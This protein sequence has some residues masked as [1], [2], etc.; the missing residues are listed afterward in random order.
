MRVLL[1]ANSLMPD[2]GGP[3][4]SVSRLAVALSD[5]GVQVGLWASDQSAVVTPLLRDE[6]RVTR[7]GGSESDAMKSFAPDVLHDNGI[8]MPHHHRYAQLAAAGKI[9]RL[10]STRGMLAPWALGH[11]RWKKRAAWWLYQR[12]DLKRALRHHV[13]ADAEAGHVRALGLGVPVCVI[14]NGIDL[15]EMAQGREL[16][17]KAGMSAGGKRIALFLGRIYPVKGLPMLIEAW[18]RVRPEGWALQLAG[19]DEAG[20]RAQVAAVITRT[21]L[22]DAISFAGPI[23]GPE[24]QAALFSAELFVL[25]THSEN[26]G[27]AVGEALAHGLPVLTTTGA[28]WPMLEPRGC[29]WWVHPTVEGLAA[30]LARATSLDTATLRAMGDRGRDLVAAEFDWGSVARKF[31][32]LYRLVKR[33]S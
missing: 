2:Y 7:L 12:R 21:G 17:R 19:P 30:G 6:T 29:G 27:M 9:P 14:P 25:P 1:V 4:Y 10:V 22:A 24:K 31:E 15:P 16:K 33:G 5:I 18:A 11:K 8:W 13:T 23:Y 28:P 3:A 26:F 20:H 32:A